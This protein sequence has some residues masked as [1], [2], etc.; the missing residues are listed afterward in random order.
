M[1]SLFWQLINGSVLKTPGWGFIDL[2]PLSSN[3]RDSSKGLV[4]NDMLI[5]QVEMEALS[6]TKY[7]SS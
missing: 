2:V 5:V 7:L 4:V 6:S 1:C 3:L